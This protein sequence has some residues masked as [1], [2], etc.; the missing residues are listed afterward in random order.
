[1][2]LIWNIIQSVITILEIRVCVWMMEKFAEPR[3]SGKKQKI[4]VWIVTLGVGVAYAVNRWMAAYY[5]RTVLLVVFVTL[6]LTSIWMFRY[7]RGI[8]IFITA[9]YLLIGALLDLVIMS[10]AELVSHNPGLFVNILKVN[11]ISRIGVLILSKIMLFWLCRVI[12]KRGDKK[13]V[14]HLIRP[15]VVKVGIILC[16]AEYVLIHILTELLNHNRGI[17]R[18]FLL[19]SIFYLIA[20]FLMLSIMVVAIMYLDAKEQLK[21]KDIFLK[22][23][24]CENKRMIKLYRE[25]EI[26]YHDFKNHLMA[27]DGYI[28]CGELEQ[29]QAYFEQIRKPFLQKPTECKTGHNIIDLIVNYK[30]WE[31]RK[32]NIQVKCK[33]YGYID[34]QLQIA[35]EEMCSLLGN[36]WDNAIEA[37][38]KLEDDNLWIDFLINIRVGKILIEISNP[39]QE[40]QWDE[41]RNFVSSK[42]EGI[43]GIGTRTIRDIAERYHGYFNYVLQDHVFKVEL[44]ICNE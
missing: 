22:S 26:M 7:Y 34:F 42:E 38:G 20:I 41:Y 37:C 23:L 24:D 3:Y 17:T 21:Y 2:T 44:M 16:I 39:Y 35:N 4:V 5:S 9:N 8:A 30:I 33:V 15:A 10:I 40:I 6:S 28:Q 29:C 14:R 19:S 1:M 25:R 12:Y 43:H 32:Q 31:A 36:L 27:L 18:E 13:I 11:G